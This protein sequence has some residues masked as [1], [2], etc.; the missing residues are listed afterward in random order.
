VIVGSYLLFIDDQ[1]ER[2]ARGGDDTVTQIRLEEN[3]FRIQRE[4]ELGVTTKGEI[5]LS[6]I[7]SDMRSLPDAL[8]SP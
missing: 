7:S 1:R 3:V 5:D 6:E 2:S 4:I 8:S